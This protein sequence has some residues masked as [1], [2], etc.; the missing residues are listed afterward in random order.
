MNYASPP[1]NGADALKQAI[2]SQD[3][4]AVEC[5][6]VDQ[7]N[8]L[9]KAWLVESLESFCSILQQSLQTSHRIKRQSIAPN[10]EISYQLGVWEGFLQAFRTLYEEERK[11][12]DILEMT[13]SRSQNE[14]K[15]LQSLYH[16]HG[17]I[18]HR[19]LADELGMTYS[20]L[21]NAMQPVIGCGAVSASRTGHNTKY[22]L[23][24]AAKRY[25]KNMNESLRVHFI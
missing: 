10:A 15:I 12:R 5:F 22:A 3:I 7:Q 8:L 11:E 17:P 9:R 13:V 6:V 20:E 23:T 18:S 2:D 16:H 4:R 21:T 14:E 1:D 24:T 25:C 19:E